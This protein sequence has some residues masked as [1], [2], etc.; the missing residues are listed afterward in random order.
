MEKGQSG[1]SEAADRLYDLMSDE[2]E[3]LAFLES[4]AGQGIPLDDC[5]LLLESS[6]L[7]G[8]PSL[9][10]GLVG[11]GLFEPGGYKP[12]GVSPLLHWAASDGSPD[13]VRLFLSCG[14]DPLGVDQ[15]GRSVLYVLASSKAVGDWGPG[16]EEVLLE[17]QAAGAVPGSVAEAVCF[18]TLEDIQRL[19]GQGMDPDEDLDGPDRTPLQIA[20]SIGRLD[21]VKYLL[22]LN[23]D[24][25]LIGQGEVIW[26]NAESDGLTALDLAETEEMKDVL[27]AHGAEKAADVDLWAGRP[28]ILDILR[29][30]KK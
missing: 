24:A 19:V 13:L 8:L 11:R 21:V 12:E 4:A 30:Q 18:G 1:M 28:L 10:R 25:K 16:F 15:F 29:D 14:F 23:E 3:A 26:V 5:L 27:T 2:A 6:V 9:A 17:L 7:Q 20:V 22:G